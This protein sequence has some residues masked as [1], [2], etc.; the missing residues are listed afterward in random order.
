MKALTIWHLYAQALAD[1][2]KIYETRT[3]KTKYRGPVVI[4]TSA[5]PMS[6]EDKA[7]A[8]MFGIK[9]VK[10]GCVAAVADLTDCVLMDEDF[11]AV[12]SAQ[13]RRLGNWLPGNYAWTFENFRKPEKDIYLSGRQGLWT[14]DLDL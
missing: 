5:R 7:L 10:P 3:W 9:G 8:Q 14:V 2:I 1:R 4:H 11:I 13:E 12:Q 6:A